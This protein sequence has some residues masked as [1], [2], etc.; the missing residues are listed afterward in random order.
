VD[1]NLLFVRRSLDNGNT[2]FISN[3]GNENLEGWV[4]LDA[5]FVMAAI[6]NPKSGVSGVARINKGAGEKK[7]VFLQLAPGES[8][9]VHTSP[10][11]V[12]GKPYPYLEPAG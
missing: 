5:K 2:Y 9:I 7:E 4:P 12:A 8:C 10:V 6:Y 3:S 1:K 11:A